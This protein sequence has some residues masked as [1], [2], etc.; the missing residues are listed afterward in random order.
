MNQNNSKYAGHQEY[1]ADD[2]PTQVAL[3]ELRMLASSN[4]FWVGLFAVVL[5]LTIAGPF[6]TDKHL[7]HAER[8]VYWAVEASL[9]LFCGVFFAVFINVVLGRMFN[10]PLVAKLGSALLVGIPISLVVW[11]VNLVTFGSA[12]ARLDAYLELLGNCLIISFAVSTLYYVISKDKTNDETTQQP[13]SGTQFPFNKRLP[14]E[15]GSNLLY[16]TSQ[17]H[18]VEAVTDRGSHLVLMR[19]SDAIDEL[20]PELGLRIHRAH[21]VSFSAIKRSLRLKGRQM[22]ETTDGKQFPVSRTYAKAVREKLDTI[23]V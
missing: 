9:T 4:R 3:R 16:L 22:I 10:K 21:W 11:I 12:F 1:F 19:F 18:Y 6:D 8:L 23:R 17:D 13:A 20:D 15:L 14:R 2:S 7:S 5:I